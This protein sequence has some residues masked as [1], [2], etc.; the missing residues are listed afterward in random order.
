VTITDTNL[1]T[2][3]QKEFIDQVE[4]LNI[5]ARYPSH[6]EKLLRSLSESKCREIISQTKELQKWIKERL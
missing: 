1:F 3:K 4:P 5:E 6:K 2:E